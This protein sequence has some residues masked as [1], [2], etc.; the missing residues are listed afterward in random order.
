MQLAVLV[1]QQMQ[2]DDLQAQRIGD[3]QGEH[4]VHGPSGPPGPSGPAG[5][6][7]RDGLQGR[8]GKDGKDGQDGQNG[9]EGRDGVEGREGKEGKDGKDGT[10]GQNA[11]AEPSPSESHDHGKPPWNRGP[12]PGDLFGVHSSRWPQAPQPTG[13]HVMKQSP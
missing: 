1:S 7:G 13:P 4:I 8:D 2:I 5:P 9:R 3:L 12:L 10:N 11:A 6:A